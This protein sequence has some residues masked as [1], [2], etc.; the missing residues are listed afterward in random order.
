MHGSSV[1]PGGQ[2]ILLLP[3]TC[4]SC[5]HVVAF[6][7][8]KTSNI[9]CT[10]PHNNSSITQITLLNG[11]V[12]GQCIPSPTTSSYTAWL[13]IYI[14]RPHWVQR[15]SSRGA[16]ACRQRQQRRYLQ[17]SN[18][19]CG[20]SLYNSQPCIMPAGVLQPSRAPAGDQQC[21]VGSSA[22]NSRRRR[23]QTQQRNN[24]QQ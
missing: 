2:Q 9:F 17:P 1:C 24:H 6:M 22:R 14:T 21:A 16:A 18:P 11:L 8:S 7:K 5:P 10:Q 15:A 12:Q 4:W 13:Y 3:A 23:Q 19:P 20:R